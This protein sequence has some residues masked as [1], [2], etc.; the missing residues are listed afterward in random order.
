MLVSGYCIFY[1]R[2]RVDSKENNL[3]QT[4][5]RLNQGFCCSCVFT[6]QKKSTHRPHLLGREQRFFCY[7]ATSPYMPHHSG[8]TWPI[9][10]VSSH[11]VSK[12]HSEA[13]KRPLGRGPT[14]RSLGDLRSPWLLTTYPNW[15]YPLSGIH[16]TGIIDLHLV[17]L[18]EPPWFHDSLEHFKTQKPT[19]NTQ[20]TASLRKTTKCLLDFK[21][22]K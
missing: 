11:L 10:G 22:L 1:R 15:D 21:Q 13:M 2:K 18:V 8:Q 6:P 20:L 19:R 4:T 3:K 12:L 16:G 17:I 9:L 14:T 5:D 7:L